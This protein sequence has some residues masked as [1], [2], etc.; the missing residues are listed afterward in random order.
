ML[1]SAIIEQSLT[2]RRMI[3]LALSKEEAAKVAFLARLSL[4]PDEVDRMALDLGQ[5][6]DHMAMLN[7][8]DTRQVA[9]TFH[10][11]APRDPWRDDAIRPGLPSGT[12]LGNAPDSKDGQ[13]RVPKIMGETS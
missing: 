7:E 8:L 10:V 3:A 12:A 1:L 2:D 13:Y 5:V 9:P 11:N 6:L 4:T